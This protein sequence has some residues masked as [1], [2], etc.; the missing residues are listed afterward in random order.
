MSFARCSALALVALALACDDG[1]GDDHDHEN[2]VISRVELSFT[3]ADGGAPLVFAFDDP[4]GDGGASGAADRVELAAGVEYTLAVRFLNALAEPP[5]DITREIEAEAEEH[6]VFVLG[7]VSGPASADATALA[8][9]AYAD[10]ESDYGA[11]AVGDDLPVGL[12]NT[13]TAGA[14]A[15]GE[16]R[17]VLRHLP[18]LNG[19]PQKTGALP[20]DLAADRDL[21]GT[22]DVDLSFELVVR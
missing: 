14:A 9:H 8:V 10:R 12:V 4:D 21:P 18:E 17:V 2:E 16:L 6:L 5:E 11:N 19:Q 1:H 15:A 13:L 7:D 20:A 3:P 22:V